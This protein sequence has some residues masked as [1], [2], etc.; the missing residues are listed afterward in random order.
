MTIKPTLQKILKGILDT[1]DENTYNHE[2]MG[3]IKTQKRSR[4][5]IKG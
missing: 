3:I 2:R 4:Q 1:E 5:V